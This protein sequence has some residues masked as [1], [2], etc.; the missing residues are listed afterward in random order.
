MAPLLMLIPQNLVRSSYP[1]ADLPLQIRPAEFR[2]LAELADLLADSFHRRQGWWRWLFPLL[3]AGIYEDLRT[4]L[5][6]QRDRCLCLVAFTAPTAAT[7]RVQHPELI[8]TIEIAAR[9]N[10]PWRLN[11]HHYPYISNLAVRTDY[12]RR[13][14]ALQLLSACEE[15]ARHWDSS[16]LYLHVLADN[17]AARRLYDRAGFVPSGRSGGGSRP[18]WQR[19][20]RLLL[21][22]PLG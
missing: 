13:G 14:V 2:D 6:S 15:V 16:A 12:R 10:L 11:Q 18:S 1:C 4:R 8:G 3:R 22:K 5:Q 19:S 7:G 17:C 21:Q 20:T 9:S